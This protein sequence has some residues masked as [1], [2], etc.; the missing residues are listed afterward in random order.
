MTLTPSRPPS[1]GGDTLF[2]D[3]YAAYDAL[4]ERLKQQIEGRLGAFT[5]GGRQKKRELLKEAD[6]DWQPVFHPIVRTH[7]E[8]GR[9][10]LYFDPGKI[11]SIEGVSA[12]E[13]DKLIDQ[14]TGYMIQPDAEYRHKWRV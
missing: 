12:Q 11:E 1:T 8:T 4:P 2:A 10:A 13:S 3:G 14:L 9:K 5:Y 7:P 6:R